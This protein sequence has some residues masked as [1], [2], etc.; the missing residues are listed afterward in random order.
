VAL[1]SD[2]PL[3]Q[4]ALIAPE[5]VFSVP[6]LQDSHSSS[7]IIHQNP[8]LD[9]H[10]YGKI[11]LSY[12][13]IHNIHQIGAFVKMPFEY[14]TWGDYPEALIGY[15]FVITCMQTCTHVHKPI[16]RFLIVS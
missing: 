15:L 2:A 13:N 5:T 8:S 6:Q 16:A 14:K 11:K 10:G 4:Q 7:C 9:L 12:N 1:A 3:S